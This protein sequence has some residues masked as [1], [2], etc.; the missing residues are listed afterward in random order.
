MTFFQGSRGTGGNFAGF[1][2][3]FALRQ[4][5]VNFLQNLEYYMTFEVLEPNW[6]NMVSKIADGKTENVD[7]VIVDRHN[8]STPVRNNLR[9]ILT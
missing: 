6:E 4:K 8:D 1:T 2:Q 3:S 5:M 9:I 7:Q